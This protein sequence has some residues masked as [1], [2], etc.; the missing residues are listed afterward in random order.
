MDEGI[1]AELI[2]SMKR[3]KDSAVAAAQVKTCSSKLRSVLS[4]KI[5]HAAGSER[6]VKPDSV[7]NR[8]SKPRE[9]SEPSSSLVR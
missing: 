2:D 8:L 6:V 9:E 1:V 5:L 7:R 4:S 3:Q